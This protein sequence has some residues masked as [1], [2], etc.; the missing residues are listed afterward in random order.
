MNYIFGSM[1]RNQNILIISIWLKYY[2]NDNKYF[3]GLLMW[4]NITYILHNYYKYLIHH[5]INYFISFSDARKFV[6]I[7]LNIIFF[8]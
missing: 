1:D 2:K 3:K 7:F 6:L 4:Y 5:I 8:K